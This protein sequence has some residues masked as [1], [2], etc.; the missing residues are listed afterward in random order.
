MAHFDTPHSVGAFGIGPRTLADSYDAARFHYT[1]SCEVLANGFSDYDCVSD[2]TME[3][4]REDR[5]NFIA[6]RVAYLGY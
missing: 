1:C 6:V 2:F 5:E 4:F 3:A